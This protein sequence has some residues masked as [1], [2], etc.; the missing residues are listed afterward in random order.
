MGFFSGKKKI[1][2]SSVVYNLAGPEIDRPNFLKTA[3]FAS[4]LKNT[5]TF[6][7]DL[8]NSYLRGPGIRLRSFA[9]WARTSGYT[10]LVGQTSSTIRGAD[11]I[12]ETVVQD[13]IPDEVG[14]NTVLMSSSIG[15]ADFTVWVDEYIFN[16]KPEWINTNYTS[17]F[18]P[19]T[20][21]ITIYPEA[22]DTPVSF[23][24]DYDPYGTYL[25]AIYMYAAEGGA[26][27]VYVDPTETEISEG[28]PFPSTSGWTLASNDET[29]T[30]VV[31]TT[32]VVVER[33]YSDGRPAETETTSSTEDSSL[34]VRHRVYRRDQY[35]GNQPTPPE[36]GDATGGR[37][38][39]LR[40]YMHQHTEQTVDTDVDVVTVV[41]TLPGGPPVVTRTT[42]TTTTTETRV[43]RRWVTYDRQRVILTDPSP[44]YVWKYKQGSG[45]AEVDAMFAPA[46]ALGAF[47]PY[48]PI[49]IDNVFVSET[50]WPEIYAG[51]KKAYRRAA[52]SPYVKLVDN[53]ADNESLGDIDYAYVVF[54]VS[55]NVVEHACKQYLF[56]FF[57]T[58]RE[59]SS[60]GV[61]A[62]ENWK[63]SWQ[64]SRD[65]MDAWITWFNAQLDEIHPL[66]GE[67]EPVTLPYP[68]IP[69]PSIRVNSGIN[70]AMNYD[71]TISWNYITRTSGAGLGFAGAKRGQVLIRKLN[72]EEFADAIY[73]VNPE[74]YGSLFQM[75]SKETTVQ[76]I[77]IIHQFTD[78]S[79]GRLQIGGLKFRNLIYK[80]KSDDITIFEALDDPEESGF[81]IPLHEEIYKSMGLKY[82]TQMS[83]ASTFIV[84]NCYKVVKQKW[85]QTGIFK[86]II[87]IIAIVIMY[88][89]GTDGG[90]LG[91]NAGV[92]ASLGFSGTSAIVVG[93]A[94]NAI[95][96]MVLM[97]VIQKISTSLFGEK[98][99][100]LVGA[101]ISVVAI[102]VGTAM[103]TGQ[104]L[105]AAFSGLMD[106]KNILKLTMA[107]GK[108]Y[109]GYMQ[110][111]AQEFMTEAQRVSE[112]YKVD[113]EAIQDK[114]RE[115]LGSTNG[116]IDPMIL[117]S[118]VQDL[119]Y[120]LESAESFLG[121]TLMTGSDIAEMSLSMITNFADITL[122][123][124]LTQ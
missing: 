42:K 15:A 98:W 25:Y 103:Q 40:T 50:A 37:T 43:Q 110:A 93:A 118:A 33:T 52:N 30:P 107:A 120:Q 53:I 116:V 84:F 73:Y 66:Y 6:A 54:G 79:W 63:T 88:Y 21:L 78:N 22:P 121:R 71:V 16:N 9:R 69:E 85:Y 28:D 72:E 74:F 41:D 113:S 24:A 64:A 68:P 10:A 92:G 123:T 77:E 81:I 58:L 47:F 4:L 124:Q 65:A 67:P 97:T 100:A 70:A 17:D 111:S 102:Q 76:H 56:E 106:P 96:A 99:G 48:I 108:G 112:Q 13:A 59:N 3:V 49:R 12:D 109:A 27:P 7:T 105:A 29:N 39:T 91:T 36:L 44:S 101:I 55:M 62:Y 61:L 114:M 104:S 45:N 51:N 19:D 1:Y 35:Q 2:V 31:L 8:V 14:K 87:I 83:T 11:T 60:S 18:N 34:L 38:W 89:T 20:G 90:L 75:V 119:D 57:D 82:G 122:S 46:D 80:G 23:A 86:I 32:T 115:F 117:T 95:A 94:V 5:N 26:D